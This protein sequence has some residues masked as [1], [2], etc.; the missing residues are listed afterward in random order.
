[1][2]KY[3]A[4]KDSG[5][6]WIGHLPDHWNILK[7]KYIAD[8]ANGATPSTGNAEY[9]DGDIFWVT[10]SDISKIVGNKIDDSERKITSKGLES[11]GTTIV[12]VNSIIL[13]TRAPIGN[14]AINEVELCTNQ[15][16]KSITIFNGET[17]FYYYQLLSFNKVLDSFGSGTTFKELSSERLK[18]YFVISPL[19]PEQIQIAAYLDKKTHQIDDLI[20]KI[21]NLIELLREE[22]TALINHAVTKG[23][24]PTVTVKDSGIEWLGEIPKHWKLARLGYH[25]EMI[26]PMRD[27]PTALIGD[28]PW[29]RIED[30]NGKYVSK[31]KTNQGVSLELVQQMNLKIFPTGTVLCSCSCNMGITAI[32]ETPLITNQTFIGIVPKEDISSDYLFYLMQSSGQFLNVIATGAIQSYLSRSDFEKLRIP[33]P[34]KEEQIEIALFIDQKTHQIDELIVKKQ[35]LIDQ[36]ID[37]KTSLI[38][39]AVTGKIDVRDYKINHA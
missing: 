2:K 13:T 15:G 4:Y 25:S 14:I 8:I 23:L 6:D 32:V 29:L 30:F 12:Q 3:P 37:Y 33:Y 26:V 17:T 20:D 1:M 35:K 34:K 36:L 21:Q 28:I 31:S 19:L 16:C 11:C 7:L 18:N 24:D 22:R 27:K 9:W 10:P 38:N 5:I 39:K